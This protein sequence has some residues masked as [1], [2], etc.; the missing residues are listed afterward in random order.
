MSFFCFRAVAFAAALLPV[1]ATAE[2]LTL[3]QALRRAVQRSEAA[4]SAR[5]GTSSAAEAA[6]TAGQL[7]DPMLGVSVENLPVTGA[8]RFS[9]TR[10]SMTMK[11][12]SIGQEWVPPEKR[13][14]RAEAARAVTAREAAN[15]ALILA[16]TRLQTSLAY[17][18]TYYANEAFKLAA[19]AES[20][21]REATATGRARLSTAGASAAD[22]LG[23]AAA[24]GSSADEALEARQQL[25]SSAVLLTRWTGSS[26]TELVPPPA[27]ASLGQQAWVDAYPQVVAKRRDIVVAQKDAAA[28]AANRSPNWSWE[29]SYGQRTGYSD[30]VSVGV[31]IPLPIAPASRQDRETASKLALVEKAEA[32]LEEATRAAAAEYQ[33]LAGDAQRLEERIRSYERS[34][35]TP[36]AQRTAAARAAFAGN[37]ASAAGFFEARNGELEARRKLLTLNRDLARV[38]AQLAFKPVKAEDL[39]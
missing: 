31:R 35:L 9:T 26:D 13:Q 17:I 20:H 16:D 33:A 19:L 28:V 25:A 21:A 34:V 30:L 39:Q 27:W 2:P 11:R 10:E 15:L 36:A 18:D 1:L 6:K 38:R 7:P 8:D 12:L 4:R 5:A 3:D 37:Q 32:D 22:V 24:Q 29:V 23:L 14:L